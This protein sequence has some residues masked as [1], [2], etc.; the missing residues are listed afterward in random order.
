MAEASNSP[1]AEPCG[2]RPGQVDFGRQPTTDTEARMHRKRRE[3]LTDH[4][5]RGGNP[6]LR[7]TSLFEEAYPTVKSVR[8]EVTETRDYGRNP[9]DP[10]D[11]WTRSFTEK[12]FQR[13]L[14][15]SNP[16]CYGGG[17]DFGSLLHAM[18]RKRETEKEVN[19]ACAGYEGS[20][21][22][23]RR[24]GLCRNRFRVSMHVEYKEASAGV[25]E[26]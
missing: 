12:D 4:I 18:V 14:D 19:Q 23:R 1:R 7:R 11:P 16:R 5:A 22:G 2:R 9:W 13:A 15:C 20:P 10:N 21:M 3:K 24:Y 17:V 6:F 8:V 26:P 25:T